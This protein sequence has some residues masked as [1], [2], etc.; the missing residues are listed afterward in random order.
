MKTVL[1]YI[2]IIIPIISFGQKSNTVFSTGSNDLFEFTYSD[3]LESGVKKIEAYSFEIKKNG[4]IKK[5]DST[6]LL[7]KEIDL[8]SNIVFGINCNI[9]YQSHGPAFYSWY[10]FEEHYDDQNRLSKYKS[11]PIEIEKTKEY[12]STTYD[13]VTDITTLD[14]DTTGNLIE[15]VYLRDEHHYSISKYTKDTF[16]LHTIYRP[17]IDEYLYNSKNQ[18]LKWFHTVDSTRYLKTESYDPKNDS[19]AVRCSYCHSRYLNVE[20]VYNNKDNLIEWVSYTDEGLIHTKRNY[21]YDNQDRLTKQIDSTGWYFSTIE[22]YWE[23]TTSY[24]YTDSTKTKTKINNAEA[25][26]GS[27]TP[28]TITTF[29]VDGRITS[30]CSFFDSAETCTKYSYLLTDDQL[31]ESKI[32]FPDGR[33]IIERFTFNKDG[34]LTEERYFLDNSL[35]RLVKYYYEK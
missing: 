4:R 30:S 14:Y 5:R 23:S 35:I 7:Q 18:K 8:N 24:D 17:K 21:F 28:K 16:H 11:S 15:K 3:F 10:K 25:R 26:F 22:P 9:N 2:L 1:I 33:Q 19:D 20:W 34:H 31:Q 13:V 29:D 6:L 12:G 27:S 32:E